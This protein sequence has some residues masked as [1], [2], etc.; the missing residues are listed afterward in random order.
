M[1]YLKLILLQALFVANCLLLLTE[2]KVL[3]AIVS[4]ALVLWF[5][6]LVYQFRRHQL[7]LTKILQHGLESLNDG[8]FSISLQD[9]KV[10]LFQSHISLFNQV[11]EKLRLERQ[12]LYQREMLLD[13]V[14]NAANVVTLL[15]NHRDDLVFT[16]LAAQQFF[17]G[18]KD[19][20]G[21]SMQAVCD[22]QLAALREYFFAAKENNQDTI[23]YLEDIE[24][25]KQA[26][27][28]TSSNLKLNGSKHT[29]ILVKPIS[30]QLHRQEIITWKKV[31]RV[32]NHE[33]NNSLAPI[34]SMCHSGNMIAEQKDDANLSRVFKG[35]TKRVDH[36]AT[37][38][39]DYS[40]LAKVK[41]PQRKAVDVVD[42]LS[43]VAQLYQFELI[44]KSV[45]TSIFID[46]EQIE[47]VLINLLKNA[48]QA[49]DVSE[50]KVHIFD[51]NGQLVISVQDDG[52]GMSS[53]ALQH[54]FTPYFSTKQ[55]G[56][57]IG[58][59]ICREIIDAHQGKISLNNLADN[60]GVRVVIVLPLEH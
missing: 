53:E 59:A 20:L 19:L 42:L 24:G 17:G 5:V 37:F 14:I 26:W 36:L 43:Q 47:Q 1:I 34:S 11:I 16:N 7:R 56:S 50:V 2:H 12:Y 18:R 3:F 57:G 31:V 15:F 44:N 45:Q 52:L 25:V 22:G 41:Q 32:I 10:K 51:Q 35:I 28:V 29:L 4:L 60:Q 54:A 49:P 33:L 21:Q 23:V 40:E 38:V 8:D 48:W 27:H 46:A 55:D 6:L 58:L 39:K 13:K 30:E 9:S